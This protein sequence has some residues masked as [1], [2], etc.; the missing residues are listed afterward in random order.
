M[1]DKIIK[2]DVKEEIKE[3][4]IQERPR[5]EQI[6]YWYQRGKGSIQ[7]LA[8]IFNVEVSYILDLI[9]EGHSSSVSVQGDLIDAGDAGP[10]VSMNYGKDIKIPFDVR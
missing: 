3:I 2:N 10:G 7:D 5:D 6:V 4:P 1:S 8:R 9:G